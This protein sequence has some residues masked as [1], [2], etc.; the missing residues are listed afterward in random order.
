MSEFVSGGHI[1]Y[2]AVRMFVCDGCGFGFDA[3]HT[4][5]DGDGYD[6]PNC[7]EVRLTQRRDTLLEACKEA[8]RHLGSEFETRDFPEPA[9]EGSCH[10]DAGCDGICADRYHM[11]RHNY[12][13]SRLREAIAKAEEDSHE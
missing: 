13:V 4:Q 7:A 1:E 12:T 5:G 3:I 10:P 9:H 6:C 2:R 8:L 11:F